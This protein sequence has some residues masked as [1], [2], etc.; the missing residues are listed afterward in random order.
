M[1]NDY[2]NVIWIFTWWAVMSPHD[3]YN[4]GYDPLRPTENEALRNI[5]YDCYMARTYRATLN[6]RK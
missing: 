6:D 2:D 5:G 1:E 4:H 3:W